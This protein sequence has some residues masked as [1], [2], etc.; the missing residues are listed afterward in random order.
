MRRLFN[1]GEGS[2][3]WK[4]IPREREDELM[5][6]YYLKGGHPK[7]GY[8]EGD[9]PREDYPTGDYPRE[10]CPRGGCTNGSGYDNEKPA[11]FLQPVVG[12][13]AVI[14]ALL[15]FVSLYAKLLFPN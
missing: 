11:K 4:V 13:G 10:E 1:G 5:E 3:L 7:G 8:S 9:F 2:D 15:G 6:E 12:E 14:A